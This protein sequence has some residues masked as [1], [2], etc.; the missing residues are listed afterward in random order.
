[1][2]P[3]RNENPGACRGKRTAR[4]G[5][6]CAAFVS[7]AAGLV[8]PASCVPADE[9]SLQAGKKGYEIHFADD[10]NAGM[11]YVDDFGIP[12]VIAVE[13]SGSMSKAPYSGG[14]LKYIQAANALGT[15]ADY[16]E[17]LSLAQKD[18]KLNVSVIKFS[19]TVSTLL[20]LTALDAEGIQKLRAACVPDK[21]RPSGSTAI[22]LALEK[23]CETL[24]QS[25]TIFNSLIL[26]TDGDNTVEPDPEK[27]IEA[28][29]A[30]RNDKSTEDMPIRTS[31]QLLSIIGF[32]IESPQFGKFHELGAR[33]TSSGNQKELEESLKALLEADITKLEGNF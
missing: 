18:M 12:I 28:I 9:E 32:D 6:L 8:V 29:Y 5:L 20:P 30:N 15:V 14:A 23:G 21:L 4:A 13:V 10:F 19:G 16:L 27:V 24:A 26:V 25:G 7:I 1:M 31:T 2:K 17:E 33:I 22:G 3:N 11:N